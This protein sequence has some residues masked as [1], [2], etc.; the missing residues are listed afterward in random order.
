MSFLSG[1][2][3]PEG[4]FEAEG[5]RVALPAPAVAAADGR[6]AARA[7]LLLG[8]RPQSVT[9]SAPGAGDA[10]GEVQLLES[11]GGDTI[12]VVRVGG[13]LVRAVVRGAER[14]REGA[15]VGLVLDPGELHLFDADGHA[16][17]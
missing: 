16:L 4:R 11:L 17:R 13:Q 2:G 7:P 5:V 12:V 6:L 1:S 8:V 10:D 3:T 14:P 15:P 9:L